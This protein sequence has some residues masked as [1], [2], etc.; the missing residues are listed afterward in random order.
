MVWPVYEKKDFDLEQHGP[1]HMTPKEWLANWKNIYGE[2]VIDVDKTTK[3]LI[4]H[5][6]I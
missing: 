5:I 6:L 2:I 3:D 1:Y 4:V